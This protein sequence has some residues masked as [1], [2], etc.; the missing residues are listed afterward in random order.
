[1][2]GR[3]FSFIA[4]TLLLITHFTPCSHW[5]PTN[6][7]GSC[8]SLSHAHHKPCTLQG[9]VRCIEPGSNGPF[10]TLSMACTVHLRVPYPVAG[11]A[12][13]R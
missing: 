10:V 3:C 2:V 6:D 1:M 4:H 13:L 8:C 11:C 9:S 5:L 12:G 7:P